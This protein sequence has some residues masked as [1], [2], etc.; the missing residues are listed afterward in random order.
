MI[1][2]T[3]K[4]MPRLLGIIFAFITTTTITNG[5]SSFTPLTRQPTFFKNNSMKNYKKVSK[6]NS[7]KMTVSADLQAESLSLIA[8]LTKDQRPSFESG[9]RYQSDD[10]LR[11]FLSLPNSF[12]LRRIRF[13][14]I[15][16]TLLS[17]LVVAM[18]KMGYGKYFTIPMLGHSLLGSFLGLLMVF[19]TNSGYSRFWE[20]RG[21]WSKASSATRVIALSSVTYL[22]EHSPKSATKLIRLLSAF[23]NALAHRCLPGMNKLPKETAEMVA[24]IG[25]TNEPS[26]RSLDA[27]MVLCMKMHSTIQEAARESPTAKTNNL[28]QMHLTQLTHDVDSLVSALTSCE[29]IIQTPVPFCYS[30]HTSRFL[31]LWSGTLPMALANQLG[32]LTVPVVAVACWCLFGIEEIGYLIEQPFVPA[33]PLEGDAT[34]TTPTNG[35]IIDMTALEKRAAST[36]PY[37]IGLP[38]CKLAEKMESE[39]LDIAARAQTLA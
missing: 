13:H 2:G 7:L 21:A 1:F 31:T 5:Y 27:D 29:K 19:R 16:N 17:V 3:N 6:I 4:T 37:D 15:S 30:R 14:L 18:H 26:G 38:V 33:A 12:V 10:W 35:E 9:H 24:S 20:A 28:E 34:T 23:P 8:R 32:A 11:K 36:Q 39:I 25:S 22:K